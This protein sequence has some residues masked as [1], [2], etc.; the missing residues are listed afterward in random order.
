MLLSFFFFSPIHATFCTPHWP[1]P[2]LVAPCTTVYILQYCPSACVYLWDCM[3]VR[4]L[5][6]AN[7]SLSSTLL[8]KVQGFTEAPAIFMHECVLT[9]WMP[10]VM[11]VLQIDT[12]ASLIPRPTARPQGSGNE[13]IL[14]HVKGIAMATGQLC[15]CGKVLEQVMNRDNGY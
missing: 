9:R 2:T 10:V 1:A 6:R 3:R 12:N 8:W 11:L 15:M 7:H 5:Y 4:S 13:T 14:M